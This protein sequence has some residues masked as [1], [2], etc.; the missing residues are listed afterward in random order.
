MNFVELART[1]AEAQHI[2]SCA[3]CLKLF[4]ELLDQELRGGHLDE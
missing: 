4:R 3:D 2:Q 1:D